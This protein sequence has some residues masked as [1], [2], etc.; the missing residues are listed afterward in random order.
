[1]DLKNIIKKIL[2]SDGS[3]SKKAA[4][5]T[6]WLFCFRI[7][8]QFLRLGRTVILARLLSPNDF[9]LFGITVMAVSLLETFSQNGFQQALT[10][11]KE[12][13][14]PYLDTSWVVQVVR[15]ILLALMLFFLAPFVAVFFK[16]PEVEQIIKVVGIAVALQGLGNVAAVYFLKELEFHKYFFYQI[17]GTIADFIVSVAAAIVWH[18]VWALVFGLLAGTIVRCIVSYIVYPYHPHFKFD[19]QKTK[20]LSNFGKWIFVSNIVAF[21]IIQADSFFVA[22]IIGVAALGFYQM[23][24]KIPSILAIEIIAGAIFPAYS[25]I[26]DNLSKIKEAYLKTLKLFSFILIPMAGGIFVLAP[27]FIRLFMGEIWLPAVGP[28]QILILSTLLWTLAFLSDYVF[29]ALGKPSIGTMGVSIRLASLVIFLY[30]LI[31]WWGLLGAAMA[32]LISVLISAGWFSFKLIKIIDCP[33]KIFLGIFIVPVMN[34]I[35]MGIIVFALKN[36]VAV[37]ILSFFSLIIAGV[38]IYFFLTY[39]ADKFFKN[40]MFPLLKESVGLLIK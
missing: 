21:F 5:G 28:M 8:D 16:A 19:F 18:N 34:T 6:F 40:R 25:K 26:Q 33:V 23:A 2:S 3:I 14:K 38:I 22:K 11:K 30:P 1:M 29:M 36:V 17:I 9:G 24:Y 32:V 39:I 20:E 12:D 37:N 27:E 13:I 7:A 31:I 15:G 10:Q 35:C 4:Q